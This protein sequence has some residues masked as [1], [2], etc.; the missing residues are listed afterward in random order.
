MRPPIRSKVIR[1]VMTR[2]HDRFKTREA[3]EVYVTPPDNCV[4]MTGS[5]VLEYGRKFAE[6]NFKLSETDLSV[7]S[8]IDVSVVSLNGDSYR[9]EHNAMYSFE[10]L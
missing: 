2:Y 7:F 6:D 9:P 10:G 1:I 5:A 8:N 4:S 3:F